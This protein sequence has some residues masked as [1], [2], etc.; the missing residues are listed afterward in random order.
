MR[1]CHLV[2]NIMNFIRNISTSRFF[3]DIKNLS[4]HVQTADSILP[5]IGWYKFE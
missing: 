2:I 3:T 1:H 4:S 5:R